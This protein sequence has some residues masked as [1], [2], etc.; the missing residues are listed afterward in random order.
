[1]KNVYD[2]WIKKQAKMRWL[3]DPNE[4]NVENLNNVRHEASWYFRNKKKGYWRAKI[5]ELETNSK[6]KN[7]RDFY[8]DISAFKKGYQLRTHIGKDMKGDLSHRLL[9]YIG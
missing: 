1:M 9:Q 4:S 2:F 7:I 3:Q 5:I 8:T 6:I